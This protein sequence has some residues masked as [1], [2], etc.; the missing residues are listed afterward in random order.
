MQ[1]DSDDDDNDDESILFLI[2]GGINVGVGE[3]V[4][5]AMGPESNMVGIGRVVATLIEEDSVLIRMMEGGN[6]LFRWYCKCSFVNSVHNECLKKDCV[7][8]FWVQMDT[9][10]RRVA[11][12]STADGFQLI[13]NC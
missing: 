6:G 11:L 3:T 1:N 10:K 4:E 9:I 8:E 5:V 13:G 12:I 7:Q 2:N